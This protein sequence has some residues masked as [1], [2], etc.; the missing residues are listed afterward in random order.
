MAEKA[1]PKN[2]PPVTVVSRNQGGARPQ[3]RTSGTYTTVNLK[4]AAHNFKAK[5]QSKA[6]G[7][8]SQFYQ[9]LS[10]FYQTGNFPQKLQLSRFKKSY[11]KPVSPFATSLFL[12]TFD[13]LTDL[14]FVND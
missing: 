13:A 2:A 7:Q 5:S 8:R 14:T 10:T 11:V 3:I 9:T 12:L 4:Q 1:G 6:S